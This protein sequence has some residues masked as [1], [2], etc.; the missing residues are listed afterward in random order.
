MFIYE[1]F[2]WKFFVVLLSVDNIQFCKVRHLYYLTFWA[3]FFSTDGNRKSH[4]KPQSFSDPTC[5][6]FIVI[7]INQRQSFTEKFKNQKWLSSP[8]CNN[9]VREF[10]YNVESKVYLLLLENNHNEPFWMGQCRKY[11]SFYIQIFRKKI[12]H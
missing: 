1:N 11:V 5:L 10:N 9:E 7:Y 8:E 12:L 6:R 4:R 3:R 2:Q